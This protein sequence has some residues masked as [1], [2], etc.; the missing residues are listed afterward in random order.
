MYYEYAYI[1]H[2]QVPSLSHPK[3]S[4]IDRPHPPTLPTHVVEYECPG[5]CIHSQSYSAN[6]VH[7]RGWPVRSLETEPHT[8]KGC[9]LLVGNFVIFV[10]TTIVWVYCWLARLMFRTP[11]YVVLHTTKCMN[12]RSG[13]SRRSQPSRLQTVTSSSP[14]P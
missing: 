1:G 4:Q 11:F 2:L 13:C 10:C 5:H 6:F 8:K 12:A 7:L 9:P 14:L 3:C